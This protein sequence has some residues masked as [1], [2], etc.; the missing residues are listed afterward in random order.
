MEL[1]RWNMSD[2]QVEND[3]I[4]LNIILGEVEINNDQGGSWFLMD[5]G[6]ALVMDNGSLRGE[7]TIKTKD[8]VFR[9]T[10][11]VTIKP[12]N[13]QTLVLIKAI[14][15]EILDIKVSDKGYTYKI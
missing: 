10:D 5:D 8:P 4:R 1:W 3:K 13:D 11:M 7:F 6:Y 15:C 9:R 2:P 14:T 12:G